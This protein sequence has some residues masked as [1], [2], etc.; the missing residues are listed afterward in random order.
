MSALFWIPYKSNTSLNE[1]KSFF[2]PF[3]QVLKKV[4]VIMHG[5]VLHATVKMG[6]L[7]FR[8]L[9]LIS[10]T[11]PRHILTPS[12]STLLSRLCIE[13]LPG[14]WMSVMLSKIQMNP[15]MKEY[16]SVHHP[17]IWTCLKNITLMLL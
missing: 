2:H 16:V 4:T 6:V 11:V 9:I 7:I 12:E 10:P 17:I 13:S 3:I 1:Q 5:N 15:F 8:V 14:F